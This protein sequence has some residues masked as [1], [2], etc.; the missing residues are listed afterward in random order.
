M[1]GSLRLSSGI[2]IGLIASIVGVLVILLAGLLTG[3]GSS[4]LGEAGARML[5]RG[6][7]TRTGL[8]PAAAYLVVHTAFY[9]AAGMAAVILARAADRA[10]AVMTG[11]VLGVIMIEFGFL[12]FS[13]EALGQGSIGLFAW[14]AFLV[15]HGVADLTFALLFLQAHPI[16]LGNLRSGYE[17]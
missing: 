15:A 9:L 3:R 11:I 10:P 7:A 6:L 2:R 12:V 4:L 14:R 5:P 1:P 8:P 17:T 16:L 13:T